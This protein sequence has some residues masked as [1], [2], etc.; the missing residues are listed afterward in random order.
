MTCVEV[1]ERL[2]EHV[3]GVLDADAVWQVERHLEWCP[4]CRKESSELLE[5]METLSV[6]MTPIKPPP[7]LEDR[8]VRGVLTAAG[9]RP[10]STRRRT[11]RVLAAAS[12]AAIIFALGAVSW[13]FA[14]RQKARDL[15]QEARQAITTAQGL[16]TVVENLRSQFGV[17]AKGYQAALYP[18][19]RQQPAGTVVV[20][21][22]ARSR[23]PGFVLVD[24]VT[25]LVAGDGPFSV[26]LLDA[27]GHSMV[28][29]TLTPNSGHL[30]MANINLL[31]DP[32][33]PN[34]INL[35]HLTT[36]NVV[37]GHGKPVLTGTFRPYA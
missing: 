1:R 32:S 16:S 12:M 20:F 37:D 10:R 36:L 21:A 35:A 24:V 19:I 26:L 13:G 15:Q 30:V 22:P 5:G 28:A 25:P 11:V 27:D 29:G 8:V 17:A 23:A 18:G 34:S 14:E 6:S 7:A 2:T 9:R 4:G 31:A 33:K 3:L